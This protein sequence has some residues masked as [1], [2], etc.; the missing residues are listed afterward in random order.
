[1]LGLVG[2]SQCNYTGTPLTQVGTTNTFCIDNT[3]SITT[4]SVRAGQYVVVNV[5]KG[6]N[7]TFSIGNGSWFR[8]VF[9]S[10]FRRC[11]CISPCQITES[12]HQF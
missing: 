5:V 11:I 12:K 1:M 3:T 10:Q 7:Y 6:F 9:A 2:F 8:C 4:A